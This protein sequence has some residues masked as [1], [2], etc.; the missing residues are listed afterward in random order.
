MAGIATGARAG[1]GTMAT[2]GAGA[3]TGAAGVGIEAIAAAVAEI[4]IAATGAAAAGIATE[5]GIATGIRTGRLPLR[6]RPWRS[7][8]PPRRRSRAS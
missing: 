4:G 5:I 7:T 6:L 2:A 1:T 3:A 8:S